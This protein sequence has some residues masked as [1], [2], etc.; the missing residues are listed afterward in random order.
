M[1]PTETKLTSIYAKIV[2]NKG[3]FFNYDLLEKL[4]F[5][6]EINLRVANGAG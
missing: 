3:N 2:D 5:I 1:K 6:L 4:I